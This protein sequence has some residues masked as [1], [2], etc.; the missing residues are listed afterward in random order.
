MSAVLG[1]IGFTVREFGVVAPCAVIVALAFARRVSRAFAASVAGAVLLAC[2]A[3]YVWH[4]QLSGL[5][6]TA[7]HLDP[8]SLAFPLLAMFTLGF[9][10]LPAT[11]RPALSLL[12]ARDRLT[13]AGAIATAVLA[14]PLY[15]KAHKLVSADMLD[16]FGVSR[17]SV[18]SGTRPELFP[19]AAWIV[20]NVVA[21]LGGV[22]LVVVVID[23]VRRRL[24]NREIDAFLPL[25][26]FTVAYTIMIALYGAVV[27]MLDDRYIWPLVLPVAIIVVGRTERPVAPERRGIAWLTVAPLLVLFL[28]STTLNQDAAAYDGA[29]WAAAQALVDAGA[30]PSQVDGGLEWEGS[31]STANADLSARG[32]RVVSPSEPYYFGFWPPARRCFVVSNSPPDPGGQLLGTRTYRSQL[33]LRTRSLYVWLRPGEACQSEVAALRPAALTG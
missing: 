8:R 15:V 33:G 24:R 20:I 2:V 25:E 17:Q 29:R 23:L 31:H 21:L 14:L 12:R 3:F 28:T 22:C 30:S 1:F 4:G 26:T 18:L 5:E 11:L 6:A 16:R 13:G 10:V 32:K 9:Y 7:L 27:G 19:W